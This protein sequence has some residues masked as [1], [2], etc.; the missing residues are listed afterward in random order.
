MIHFVSEDS[1]SAESSQEEFSDDI[2]ISQSE[3][4]SRSKRLGTFGGGVSASASSEG[5]SGNFIFDLIR[6]SNQ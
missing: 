4:N 3:E 6:V 5:G 2:D 1:N